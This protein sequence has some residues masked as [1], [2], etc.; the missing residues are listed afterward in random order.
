[1]QI[2]PSPHHMAGSNVGIRGFADF[3]C[4]CSTSLCS[5]DDEERTNLNCIGGTQTLRELVISAPFLSRDR[6]I[7]PKPHFIFGDTINT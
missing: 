4:P 5:Y 1:M 2:L 7:L 6:A 3:Q